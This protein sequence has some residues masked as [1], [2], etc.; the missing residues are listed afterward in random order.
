MCPAMDSST[1]DKEFGSLL[2]TDCTSAVNNTT[3][4]LDWIHI[5]LNL[6]ARVV[7]DNYILLDFL[8]TSHGDIASTS[9]WTW[10]N[11]T[12]KEEKYICCLNENLLSVLSLVL[13]TGEIFC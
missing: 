5:C 8:S 11:E 13:M 3:S 2:I 12:S 10:I 6:F 9:S 7:M 4:T 1:Q